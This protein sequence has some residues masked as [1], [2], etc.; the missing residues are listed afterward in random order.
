[1]RRE[2]WIIP[3]STKVYNVDEHFKNNKTIVWRNAFT[4]CPGDI[5]YIYVGAPFSEIKYKCRVIS[6]VIDEEQL[7]A[8]AY[9]IPKKK[10]NNYFSKK[11]KY[12][13]LELIFTFPEH[14]LTLANLR[15]HGLGQ[16]Q[17][18]AR[19]DRRLQEYIDS[20]EDEL[21]A[22]KEDKS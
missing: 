12:V 9:A 20:I 16:V 14:A 6:N 1:M 18:Q 11:D 17:I 22:G 21:H 10:V 13:E 2:N 4:I 3:C 19:T 5:A 7:K 15:R 8:N